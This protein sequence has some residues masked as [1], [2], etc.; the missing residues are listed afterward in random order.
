MI[1][2]DVTRSFTIF[3]YQC[4]ML[5]LCCFGNGPASIGFGAEPDFFENHEL[6]LTDNVDDIA[7]LNEANSEWSSVFYQIGRGKRDSKEFPELQY[8]Q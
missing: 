6:S 4:G 5:H 1:A 3:T 8:M 7:C 2:S